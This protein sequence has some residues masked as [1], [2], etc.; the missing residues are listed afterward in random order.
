VYN[1]SKFNGKLGGFLIDSGDFIN[2]GYDGYWWIFGKN[3]YML[4]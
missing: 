3:D 2:I 4:N 1:K